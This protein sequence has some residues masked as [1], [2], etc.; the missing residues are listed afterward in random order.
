LNRHAT[1]RAQRESI[2]PIVPWA[3][4]VLTASGAVLA[5]FAYLAVERGHWRAAL[6]WLG[7][8]LVV[9]GIDGPLARW[10]GV[11]RRTPGVD[12]ST[13]DLVVD[14]L[15]YVFVPTML[16]YRDGLLP[17]PLASVG[18]AAI[19]VSS[20][21]TFARTDM[22]TAD[23]F[24]LGFPAL[25]NVVAFYLFM[26]QP[27][28]TTGAIVVGVFVLLTFAPVHFVHPVRVR[29]HQP[30]LAGITTVWGLSSLAL[31][32]PDWTPFWVRGLLALSLA[33]AG[34]LLAIGAL[35]MLRGPPMERAKSIG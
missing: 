35:R 9:D 14:Y 1:A 22:K 18:V 7:A 28:Q 29:S 25:W 2:P 30:W 26:L 10:A 34:A 13:L 15:T 3:I 32:A 4:H 5:F 24:F 31:L 33:S 12:G 20:L 6:L 27:G 16:I 21:Y 17:S 11:A 23:N 19:L 8:A